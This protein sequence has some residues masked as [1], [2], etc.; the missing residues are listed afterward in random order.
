[1]LI[2]QNA[3]PDID[4]DADPSTELIEALARTQHSNPT[5][6]STDAFD[7]YLRS[8]PKMDRTTLITI[9]EQSNEGPIICRSASHTMA[10]A[11]SK[12]FWPLYEARV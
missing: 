1:M 7:A 12:V 4:E 11:I 8:G 5:D 6:R 10:L 2:W 3:L 9:L